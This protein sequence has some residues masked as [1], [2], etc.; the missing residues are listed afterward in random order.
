MLRKVLVGVDGTPGGRD[1][2]ALA[3]AL[4]AAGDADVVLVGAYTDPLLPFPPG[5]RRD[6]T[7]AARSSSCCWRR[8]ASWR[9]RRART[10]GPTARRAARCVT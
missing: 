9:P 8:A 5:L 6:P 1:A 3:S 7:S 10:C 2:V 4:A